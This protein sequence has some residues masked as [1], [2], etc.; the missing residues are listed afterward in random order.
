MLSKKMVFSLMRLI[1]IFALAFVV[2]SAM[3]ADD[4]DATFS[5][6]N[7]VYATDI[8]VTLKFGEE[9]ALTTAERAFIIVHVEDKNGVRTALTVP[10][11]T[12]GTGQ[13]GAGSTSKISIKDINDAVG[14][15]QTDRKT[16]AFTIAAASTDADDRKVHLY[17]K[18]GCQTSYS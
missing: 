3:A 16:F 12:D 6:I 2:P 17:I 5:V 11:I 13:V 8:V 18:I 9:V 7:K 10:A 14:G 15:V 1:T 4:F